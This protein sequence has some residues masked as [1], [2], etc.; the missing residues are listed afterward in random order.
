MDSI[1]QAVL[2]SAIQGAL[3]GRVQGRRALVYGAML[4]T[5]PDL[6]VIIR[7][8]DPV[9][10]MTS[11]RGFSHSVFVLT[12]LAGAMTWLIRKRWPDAGYTGARL[13]VTIW[14]VLIT[15][16]LLDALTVYGTQLFWPFTPTPASWA[17]V[18]IIDPIYSVPLLLGVV[19]AAIWGM[20]GRG[21]VV[22]T[23]ALIFT[24]AYMGFALGARVF[25]E[26]RVQHA[27]Q[28]QGIELSELRAVPMPFNSLLWRVIA[29]TPDG[30]YVEAV[31]SLFDK[32]SPEWLRL[33][34]N[35]Q[36]AEFLEKSEQ[37]HRL[38]WFTGD[39]LRYDWVGNALVVSDLRMGAAGFYTFRFKMAECDAN[40]TAVA[41]APTRWAGARPGMDKLWLAFDRIF[42]EEPALPLA[43]FMESGMGTE[44]A[45]SPCATRRGNKDAPIS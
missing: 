4:G 9:S 2:G 39:W 35:L 5:L 24:T 6:D 23:C 16:T 31:S 14:L 36:L 11:H 12:A 27:M 38:R 22:L 37:H 7:Y 32:R 17:A 43:A 34:L 19:F 25:I 44:T 33:P 15:H 1:T 8:A 18:F 10:S 40:G 3:L 41:V 29:K 30:H 21:S 13:F 45:A 42:K 20:A 28:Q 26:N